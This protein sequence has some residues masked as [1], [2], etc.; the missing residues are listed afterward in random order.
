MTSNS[1]QGK[2]STLRDRLGGNIYPS[3]KRNY[4]SNIPPM[5]VFFW[6]INIKIITQYL[7]FCILHSVIINMYKIKKIDRK[8]YYTP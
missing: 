3:K 5:A 4:Y 7:S 2:S 8:L 6:R 1:L